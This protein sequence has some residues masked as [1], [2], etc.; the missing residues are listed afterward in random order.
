MNAMSRRPSLYCWEVGQFDHRTKRRDT[1]VL[2]QSVQTKA[3]GQ[4]KTRNNR[5]HTPTKRAEEKCRLPKVLWENGIIGTILALLR[6]KHCTMANYPSKQRDGLQYTSGNS[7]CRIARIV[8][9]KH[10]RDISRRYTLHF[11]ADSKHYLPLI[12]MIPWK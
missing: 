4:S 1:A 2:F 3:G 7:H 12:S 9:K 11:S 10:F 6:A 8:S 5:Y